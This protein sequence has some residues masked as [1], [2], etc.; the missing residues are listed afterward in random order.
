MNNK[1]HKDAFPLTFSLLFALHGIEVLLL[2]ASLLEEMN[3][4]LMVDH[5]CLQQ[6]FE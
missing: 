6:Q 1:G 5:V 3:I 2:L 4:T